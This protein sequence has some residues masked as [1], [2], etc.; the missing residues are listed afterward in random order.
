MGAPRIQAHFLLSHFGGRRGL[1][2]QQ[3][4]TKGE[5]RGRRGQ[6][7]HTPQRLHHHEVVPMLQARVHMARRPGEGMVHAHGTR[8]RAGAR[9][10]CARCHTRGDNGH[11]ALREER[12][13]AASASKGCSATGDGRQASSKNSRHRG[14]QATAAAP[15]SCPRCSPHL[16]LSRAPLCCAP[17][18]RREPRK[19]H[20][21]T[22]IR[23][24]PKRVRGAARQA[25][26]RSC[27][28]RF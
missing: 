12:T 7:Q 8:A 13:E 25:A 19:M 27:T 2:T 20:M 6:R 5:W 3:G 11:G 9:C 24:A 4:N 23:F 28:A 1:E 18:R 16:Q 10:L 22:M 17:G 14:G 26:A 15:R 21:S